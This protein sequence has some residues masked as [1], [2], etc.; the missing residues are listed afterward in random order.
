M[1]KPLSML[2]YNDTLYVLGAQNNV[3][4]KIDTSS[5]TVCGNI[6]L[7]TGGFSSGF[8]RIEG[9]NLAVVTDLKQNS[10]SIIDLSKG[11]L[12]K[13]YLLNVPIKDVVITEK[14]NLFD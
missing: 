11:K 8:H 7:G 5:D 6:E 14:V 4:Q 1:N 10:Y 13:T 2:L 3:I 9:T 12:L